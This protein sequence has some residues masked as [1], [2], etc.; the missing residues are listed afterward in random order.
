[1]ASI[2]TM[3]LAGNVAIITGGSSGIGLATVNLFLKAGAKVA[4]FDIQG[5]DA[6]SIGKTSIS[7]KQ[8]SRWKKA[9]RVL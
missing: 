7:S 8:T 5:N 9:S 3:P 2:S 4:V 6:M 1:M